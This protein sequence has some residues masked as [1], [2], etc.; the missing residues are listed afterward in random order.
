MRGNLGDA[1]RL[2]HILE[3]ILEI[4]SRSQFVTLNPGFCHYKINPLPN[5]NPQPQLLKAENRIAQ[6]TFQYFVL[7][8][9]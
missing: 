6:E 7:R 3:A 8:P 5:S 9:G 4:I 2:R 1:V